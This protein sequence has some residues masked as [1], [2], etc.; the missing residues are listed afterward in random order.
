MAFGLKGHQ[1]WAL[2]VL[3]AAGAWV[4]TGEFSSVGSEEAH[5]AQPAPDP[6]ATATPAKTLRSV[7]VITPAFA[8][9]AREIRIS[10]VT[11]PDKRA[12]LASRASGVIAALGVAQG[13]TVEADQI[14]L[15]VE[16]PEVAAGV[17]NARATLA[18]RAQ[19]LQVAEK[20]FK[21]GNTAELQL[22]KV[23]AD[24]AAAEA[25]LSEAKAAADRLNLRA[26][27]AGVIDSVDVELGEW[28]PIGTP[29]ATLIAL[30]PIVVRAEVS[31][32]GVGF[33]SVGD[34]ASVRLVNGTELEGTVRHISR[35]AS[36]QTRTYPIE[37]ALPNPDHKLPA[38]MTAEVRLYTAPERAVT[39][40]RSVIT[41]SD[42]GEI[43]LRVVGAD[44]VARFAG[45]ELIDDTADGFVVKGVPEG[46]KIIVAGQDLVRDGETV[47]AVAATAAA[48]GN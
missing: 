47:E 2:L 3:V 39:V 7:G 45:I 34:R 26:P 32:L 25:A 38:G 17:E 9:H 5:A 37:V 12:E 16:G 13:D 20:L 1:V 48:A 46:V 35:E 31:E 27:F 24:K 30:D 29:I 15:M 23:R 6:A 19:E 8:D 18:Q 36:P 14:V 44:N 42:A 28:V 22:I 43:G 10:G 21:S 40:P 33:V 4:V 11:G 41:L